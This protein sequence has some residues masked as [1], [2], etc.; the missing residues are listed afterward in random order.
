MSRVGIIGGGAMRQWL[1]KELSMKYSVAIYDIDPKK[2]IFLH[3]KIYQS[4][5][6]F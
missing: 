1:K 2:V 5:Q 4:W 6:K 3:L